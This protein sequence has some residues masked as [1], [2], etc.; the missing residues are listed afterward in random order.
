M[1][2]NKKARKVDLGVVRDY[3]DG[4]CWVLQVDAHTVLEGVI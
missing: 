3:A 4:K 1:E 2:D